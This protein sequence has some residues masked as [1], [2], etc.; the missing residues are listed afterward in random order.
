MKL[1]N[2]KTGDIWEFDCI[3]LTIADTTLR[4]LKAGQAGGTCFANS[5]AD[6]N[7]EWEDVPT[8]PFI[9]NEEIRKAIQ[10]W[11]DVNDYGSTTN[12][13]YDE[14]NA[15]LSS[16]TSQIEF[17]SYRPF[18]GLEDGATYTIAELCGEEEE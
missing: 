3:G 15:R 18:Y 2:K 14:K 9:K 1:R 8:E 16:R 5:L 6:L 12:L 4:K 7:D 11:A 10:A 17:D 13:K